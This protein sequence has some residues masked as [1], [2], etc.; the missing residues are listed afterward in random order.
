MKIG[1]LH[2]LTGSWSRGGAET[3]VERQ[4]MELSAQGHQIFLISTR[5][6]KTSEPVDDLWPTYYLPS[7]FYNLNKLPT[8]LRLFWHALNFLAYQKYRK[9]LKILKTEKPDLIITHNL[10]GLGW[11]APLAIRRL[12]IKQEHYLHDLQ[13]LHPSGLL[14]WGKEK[15]LNSCLARFY[16]YLT[17]Q[18]IASPE[19]IISPSNWLLTLHQQYHF[20]PNS[21][22]TVKK[23]FWPTTI[24]PTKTKMPTTPH[25]L[26]IGQIEKQKGVFLLLEAFQKLTDQNLTLTLAIRGGGDQLALAKKVAAPDKRINFLGPLSYLETEKIKAEADYLIVPSLCYE[27]SPTVIYGAHASGLCVIAAAIGGIPELLKP[28]DYSFIP[29]SVEDLKKQITL[30]A[31]H[32]KIKTLTPII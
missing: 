25:F 26:F 15:K 2:N 6:R 28:G 16:R 4:A 14:I 18:L 12:K 29:G 19:K 7:Y 1:L 5:P 3:I 31:T 17:R 10:M 8:V 20:F 23:F 27:N 21:Q 32:Q 9:I 24:I 30:A 13:L 22:T 11:L